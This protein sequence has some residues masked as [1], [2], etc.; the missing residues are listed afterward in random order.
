MNDAWDHE[1]KIER[2]RVGAIGV[3][4]VTSLYSIIY[5]DN[6]RSGHPHSVA[7]ANAISALEVEAEKALEGDEPVLV[8]LPMEG[9]AA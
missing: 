9:G 3:D 2:W 7:A 5:K 1:V 8:F 4:R 6:R